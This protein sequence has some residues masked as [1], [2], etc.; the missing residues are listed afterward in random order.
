MSAANF[1]TM[2]RFPLYA[3]DFMVE[4]KKCEDCGTYQDNENEVCE[5]CGGE[6]ESEYVFDDL[7]REYVCGQVEEKVAALNRGLLFH[8]VSLENGYYSGVQFYVDTEY[9]FDAED[10]SNEDCQYFFDMC[11]SKAY[12]KYAAEKRKIARFLDKAAKE[13][14]FKDLVCT[15][16]FS[17]G[18]AVYDLAESSR[19]RLIA[20]ACS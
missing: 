11:R 1:K 17:N 5:L 13:Y 12:R 8:K 2:E 20:A 16:V 4:M 14:G 18:E 19:A 9:D 7:E 15:A 10:F 3:R 6:L